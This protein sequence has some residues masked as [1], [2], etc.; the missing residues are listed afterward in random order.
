MCALPAASFLL[1]QGFQQSLHYKNFTRYGFQ[2]ASCTQQ[3]TEA[4]AVKNCAKTHPKLHRTWNTRMEICCKLRRRLSGSWIQTSQGLE[5]FLAPTA[6]A[7]AP[8][9]PFGRQSRSGCR[10][11]AA[12][13][14][15]ELAAP[16]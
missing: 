15:V 4:S 10:V 13:P 9:R 11:P 12:L 2:I 16:Q 6:C 3:K 1:P 8:C 5:F 14:V 7:P